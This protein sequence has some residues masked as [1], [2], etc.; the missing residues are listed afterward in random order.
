MF[1]RQALQFKVKGRS[2]A[3]G[4]V[5]LSQVGSVRALK[6]AGNEATSHNTDPFPNPSQLYSHDEKHRMQYDP[7]K[8][9][10]LSQAVMLCLCSINC[11]DL[12]Y[13]CTF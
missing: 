10:I 6:A 5:G 13:F 12:T 9:N 8:S 11:T 3:V 7:L 1:T 4:V 2:C